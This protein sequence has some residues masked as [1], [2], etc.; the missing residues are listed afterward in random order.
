MAAAFPES[1]TGTIK[2]ASILASL[3]NS[4]A[5]SLGLIPVAISNALFQMI[6]L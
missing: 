5:A 4:L 2:S 6:F 3:A 1:G